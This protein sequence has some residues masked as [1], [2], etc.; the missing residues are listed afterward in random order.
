[1]ATPNSY[2]HAAALV[3]KGELSGNIEAL[4]K[5]RDEKNSSLWNVLTNLICHASTQAFEHGYTRA[6]AKRFNE[7]VIA[8]FGIGE[9]QAMKWTTS[10]SAALGVRGLRKGVQPLKGLDV[11]ATEG[12]DRVNEFLQA[13]QVTT[14]NQFMAS[15]RTEKNPIDELA[16]RYQKLSDVERE[17]VQKLV[18]KLDDDESAADDDADDSDGPPDDGKPPKHNNNLT[19]VRK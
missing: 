1:M 8:A 9:K 4:K 13:A 5:A 19:I 17:R 16:R 14:F 2:L 11:A 15:T 10:I 6:K 3:F 18:K 12:V 7:D